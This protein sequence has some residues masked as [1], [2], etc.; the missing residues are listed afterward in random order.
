MLRTHRGPLSP[1]SLPLGSVAD[2]SASTYC[3]LPEN[4]IFPLLAGGQGASRAFLQPA[5]WRSISGGNSPPHCRPGPQPRA[6]SHGMR[7][8]SGGSGRQRGRQAEK[9]QP[10]GGWFW[11]STLLPSPPCHPPAPAKLLATDA[12]LKKR[13]KIQCVL[14]EEAAAAPQGPFWSD[15]HSGRGGEPLSG[16][17]P[18]QIPLG[19][20]RANKHLGNP[21][22][23]SEG[24]AAGRPPGPRQVTPPRLTARHALSQHRAQHQGRR[25][26]SLHPRGL[27]PI[28]AEGASCR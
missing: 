17:L 2:G 3:P 8:A 13:K 20:F 4:E 25:S 9:P 18:C 28:T 12:L 23:S 7:H 19:C 14:K 27:S 24:L 22:S 10:W 5:A 16:S 6:Q 11:L 15:S 26:L 21:L 1:T